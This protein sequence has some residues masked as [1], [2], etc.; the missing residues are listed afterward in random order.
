MEIFLKIRRNKE[1]IKN[2]DTLQIMKTLRTQTASLGSNY[3]LLKSV[4]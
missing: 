3:W 1:Q 4:L 2:H